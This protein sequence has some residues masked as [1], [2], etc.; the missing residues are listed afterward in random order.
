MVKQTQMGV[1]NLLGWGG[2]GGGGGGGGALA[3]KIQTFLALTVCLNMYKW[4][5]Q[6]K[7][8]GGGGVR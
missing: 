4:G 3:E 1:P 8:G 6:T 2:G 7:R 5:C